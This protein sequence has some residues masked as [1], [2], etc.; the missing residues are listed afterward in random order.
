MQKL[1][2]AFAHP[3]PDPAPSLDAVIRA[4][5]TVLDPELGR[6]L[7]SLDMIRDVQVTDRGVR[8]TVVLTTPA[9]PMRERIERDCR[10][11]LRAIGARDVHIRFDA[12]VTRDRRL[13]ALQI[14]NIIAVASGKGGVGKTTCAVNLALALARH[15]ARVGLLDADIYGP[16]VPLMLGLADARPAVAGRH[17]PQ[18]APPAALRMAPLQ[19]HGVKAMSLGFLLQTD[20]A[21]I[22]RGPLLHKALEQLIMD[23]AWGELDYLLLDL[24][25]GTGDV[26]LSLAQIVPLTGAALVTTPQ[27]VALADVRKSIAALRQLHVPVLGVIENMSYF[28]CDCCGKRHDLFAS[29]GGQRMAE[30]L[31]LP[32]LG[33][34]PLAQ[35][36]REGSDSG[37]PIVAAQPDSPTA[38]AFMHIAG[39]IAAGISILNHRRPTPNII[40]PEAI[41][42]C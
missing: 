35:A 36:V 1:K 13:E 6:D 12:R 40:S 38:Q 15:G 3:P 5:A 33:A 14:G 32:L 2:Y 30:Q 34:I 16:N 23:T 10:A 7:V 22:W 24:P 19:A 41:P 17:A 18:A 28:V 9:C 39:A 11:A 25:P 8:F 27:A 29:G 26:L 37:R 4:L 21:V 31:G 42:V 20:Q